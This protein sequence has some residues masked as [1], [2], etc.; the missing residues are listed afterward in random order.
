VR[1]G[2]RTGSVAL[3][4]NS[5]AGWSEDQA[6]VDPGS[7]KG[8]AI[9]GYSN[10]GDDSADDYDDDEEE[11]SPYTDRR[12]RRVVATAFGERWRARLVQLQGLARGGALSGR[13]KVVENVPTAPAE[14]APDQ[15]R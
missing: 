13:I 9:G 4:A 5:G 2:S 8:D 1:N 11:D 14:A 6:D 7:R 3:A 12:W 15:E 10:N